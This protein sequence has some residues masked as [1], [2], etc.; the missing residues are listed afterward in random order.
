MN[1]VPAT[2][3]DASS[4]LGDAFLLLGSLSFDILAINEKTELIIEVRYC[5]FNG[6][7]YELF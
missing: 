5:R 2:K 1:P 6:L 7:V 4:K 3:Q